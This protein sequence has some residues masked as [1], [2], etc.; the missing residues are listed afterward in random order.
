MG[1]V[2]RFE[3]RLRNT[4]D[5]AF[6]RVFGG[7]VMPKEVE[8]ALEREAV[9]HIRELDGGHQL[10]PNSYVITIN[11]TDH[12][13]LAAEGDTA[14]RQ[15]SRHLQDYIKAQGWQTYGD[16]GVE[17]EASPSLHTG[18]F[19]ARGIVDP[20]VGRRPAPHKPQQPGAVMPQNLP[21]RGPGTRRRP[22]PS[23][24]RAI[25]TV[26]STPHAT[27]GRP[28]NTRT[29]ATARTSPAS[30]RIALPRSPPGT[31]LPRAGV[32]GSAVRLPTPGPPAPPAVP[33]RSALRR[34]RLPTVPRPAVPGPGLRQPG[35]RQPGSPEP[36]IRRPQL[37]PR[38]PPR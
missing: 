14:K 34:T 27:L 35:V 31:A 24:R 38:P 5:D 33:G 28:S 8:T 15:F 22:G 36:G 3:R 25:P 1:I 16:V 11:S 29:H 20:D 17:F 12:E 32:L 37:R 13:K 26:I 6:A 30:T 18:Q 2:S 10:A 4:V 9:D 21:R 7:S 23:R 19:R